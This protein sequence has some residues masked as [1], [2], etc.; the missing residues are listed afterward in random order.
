[1]DRA[2]IIQAR[3]LLNEVL[4]DEVEPPSTDLPPENEWQW[5]N[6]NKWKAK[7]DHTGNLVVI[8][9]EDWNPSGVWAMRADG[10]WEALDYTGRANG[11]RTHW[12]GTHPG[13]RYLNGARGGGV[14]VWFGDEFLF[15]PLPGRSR[16]DY[17]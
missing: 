16:E 5:K 17:E 13:A 2:K 7:G 8:L 12:R 9:R 6:G 10:T 11:N 1:M 3:N 4:N 15:I 14:R